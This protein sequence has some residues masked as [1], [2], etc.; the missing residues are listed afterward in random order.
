MKFRLFITFI[1]ICLLA[2]GC[3][4]N[5]QVQSVEREDLFALQIGKLEDQIALFNLE[6]DNGL[7][8]TGIAMQNGLFYISDGNGGKILR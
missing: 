5:N 1:F 6:G 3:N 4:R 8:R 2:S 7:R